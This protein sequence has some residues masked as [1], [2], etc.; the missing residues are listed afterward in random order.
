ML[1]SWNYFT[2]CFLVWQIAWGTCGPFHQIRFQHRTTLDGLSP[3]RI[4]KKR[5]VE[6]TV[7]SKTVGRAT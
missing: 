1:I 7:K 2:F 6:I 3:L 5:Q 4:W